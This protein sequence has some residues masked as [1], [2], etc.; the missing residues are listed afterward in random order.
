MK[1]EERIQINIVM[2][3]A[4]EMEFQFKTNILSLH[5]YFIQ[6]LSFKHGE[7]KCERDECFKK[8]DKCCQMYS[9]Y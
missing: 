5:F 4:S 7:W 1:T 2:K 6:T 8:C 3:I 9:F